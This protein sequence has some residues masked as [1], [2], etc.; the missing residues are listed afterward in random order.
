VRKKKN[1]QKMIK[2]LYLKM[3][4]KMLKDVLR[5]FLVALGFELSLTFPR[6]A[7]L[8]LEPLHQPRMLFFLI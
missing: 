3:L 2:T 4:Q 8:L 5:F 7:L 6:Q 1:I